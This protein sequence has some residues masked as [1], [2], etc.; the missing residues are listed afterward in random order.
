MEMI[1]IVKSKLSEPLPTDEKLT[2]LI[3]E[4]EQTIL[5]FCN[6]RKVP[7]QLVYVHANMVVDL[8]NYEHRTQAESEDE[9]KT[10]TSIKEGDVTVQFGGSVIPSNERAMEGLLFNYK[11]QL[12]HFRRLRW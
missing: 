1:E 2:A 11:D 3:N 9:Q 4:V 5:N 6:I 8:F 10:V 12:K 7:K